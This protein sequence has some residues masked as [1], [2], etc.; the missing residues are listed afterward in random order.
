VMARIPQAV[1]DL[2]FAASVEV[3]HAHLVSN[4]VEFGVVWRG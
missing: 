1:E 4:D 3:R 2:H